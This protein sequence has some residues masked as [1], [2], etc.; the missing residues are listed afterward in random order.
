MQK[1]RISIRP[2]KES[3]LES[4]LSL[5][6]ELNRDDD[7][8]Q[9]DLVCEKYAEILAH[10]G[11]TIFLALDEETPVATASLIVIPNLTRGGRPYA[12][13]ENVV[14]AA[15]HRGQGFGKAAV[16]HAIQ[17]A[18]EAGCYKAMRLTGRS[19]PAIHRFYEACGFVQNK[20]GFQIRRDG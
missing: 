14:S 15:S 5:Y 1:S 8:L 6:S 7:L 16:C 20:T 3:D 13:I 19:D 12:L 17:A 11:L 4:L 18:W 2:A 9:A 10:P